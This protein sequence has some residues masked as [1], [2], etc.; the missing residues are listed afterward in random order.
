[1]TRPLLPRIEERATAGE[2]GKSVSVSLPRTL[3]TSVLK[4]FGKEG[5]VS[6]PGAPACLNADDPWLGYG[7]HVAI[8]AMCMLFAAAAFSQQKGDNALNMGVDHWLGWAL[9]FEIL[10]L[11][12]LG[13]ELGTSRYKECSKPNK[14]GLYLLEMW[15]AISA[16]FNTSNIVWIR[17]VTDVEFRKKMLSDGIRPG[18]ADGIVE[19]QFENFLAM[20][21]V[22]CALSLLVMAAS[23]IW[24]YAFGRSSS[25]PG[26]KKRP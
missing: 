14:G 19:R 10:H 25:S 11:S 13:W 9:V 22:S 17:A 1:M 3:S 8:F 21:Q 20:V 12:V 18:G 23:L 6:E 26:D 4:R 15:L 7:I 16:V 5:D 2:S 24:F